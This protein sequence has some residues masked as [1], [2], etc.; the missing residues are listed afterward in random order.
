M[1]LFFSNKGTRSIARFLHVSPASVTKWTN[2]LTKNQDNKKQNK[3]IIFLDKDNI[4]PYFKEKTEKA[5]PTKRLLILELDIV[6]GSIE[7]ATLK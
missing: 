5:D 4:L 2:N 7:T 3:N 1:L 6:D